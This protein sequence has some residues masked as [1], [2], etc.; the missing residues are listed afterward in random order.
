[1]TPID[2]ADLEELLATKGWAWLME[3][4]DAQFGPAA[5]LEHV[6][7]IAKETPD[8]LL[9]MAKIDQALSARLAVGGM[10]GEPQREL[11]KRREALA[12]RPDGLE[13][14]RRRGAGL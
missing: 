10:L 14:M 9:K 12:Q 3:R 8:V 1:M 7:T 4:Y 6:T 5:M 11:Q 13:G 2:I